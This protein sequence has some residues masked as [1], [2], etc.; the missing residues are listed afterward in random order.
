MPFIDPLKDYYVKDKNGKT[1]KL[2]FPDSYIL[3]EDYNKKSFV[4]EIMP[5]LL[6][7]IKAY[8]NKK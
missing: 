4:D 1:V 6:A 3:S 2:E 5:D 8:K 7:L